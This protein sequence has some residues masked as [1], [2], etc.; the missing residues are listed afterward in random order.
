M[1][2]LV[3]TAYFNYLTQ[4][5]TE[6]TIEQFKELLINDDNFNSEWSN[7]C[8][9]EYTFDER[10]AIAEKINSVRVTKVQKYGE[11]YVTLALNEL[12]IPKREILTQ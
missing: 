1:A 8:T 11:I 9:R 5:T 2:T 3:Q 6:M 4:V 7:G 12:K 10:Y